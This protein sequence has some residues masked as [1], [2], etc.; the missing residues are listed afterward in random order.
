MFDRG[1]VYAATRWVDHEFAVFDRALGS[2]TASYYPLPVA[3]QAMACDGGRIY[4][5]AGTAPVIY[6]VT[7]DQDKT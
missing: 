5:L 2:T 3:P 7:F 1:H 6:E 4:V